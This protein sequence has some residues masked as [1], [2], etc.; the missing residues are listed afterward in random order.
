MKDDKVKVECEYTVIN[1]EC[2]SWLLLVKPEQE[3]TYQG[4]L[5]A[6]RSFMRE[7]NEMD[8]A[9]PTEHDVVQ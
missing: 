6:I 7:S 8:E 2:G 3:I 9:G 1:S 5:D 4:F